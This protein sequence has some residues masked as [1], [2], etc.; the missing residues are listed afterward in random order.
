MPMKGRI[1]YWARCHQARRRLAVCQI[2]ECAKF[3]VKRGVYEQEI[4]LPNAPNCGAPDFA[5]IHAFEPMVVDTCDNF[6]G[7]RRALVTLQK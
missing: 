3:R 5:N 7:T 4:E 2:S 6:R 1:A